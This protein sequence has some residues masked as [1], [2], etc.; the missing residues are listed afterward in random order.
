MITQKE[1]LRSHIE[2]E[3]RLTVDGEDQCAQLKTQG[4]HCVGLIVDEEATGCK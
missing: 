3:G 4:Q 1:K 2:Q